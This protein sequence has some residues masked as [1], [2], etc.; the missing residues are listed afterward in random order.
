[1]IILIT[2]KKTAVATCIFLYLYV[3]TVIYC[4]IRIN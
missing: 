2:V 1:M 4:R 3:S